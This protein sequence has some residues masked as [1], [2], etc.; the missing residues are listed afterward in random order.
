[1]SVLSDADHQTLIKALAQLPNPVRLRFFA[2]TIGCETCDAVRQLL[3]A[4]VQSSDK[5][6]LEELNVVL[7]RDQALTYGFDRAPALA[8]VTDRETGIRFIGAPLG[9]EVGSLVEAI[10]IA[11]HRDSGLTDASRSLVAKVSEPIHIQVFVTPTCPHCP[12]AVT[13]AH[14]MALENPQITATCVDATEFPDLVRQYRVTGVPKTVA[15]V[16]GNQSAAV[17]ILGAVP[18]AEFV[19]Q[20][21]GAATGAA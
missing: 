18:E 11:S 6:A 14:R 19:G 3:N 1:M 16:G 7:D 17:E 21:V 5:I 2:Q 9:Y 8:L 15:V 10:R 13:L 12:R 4:F 20:I